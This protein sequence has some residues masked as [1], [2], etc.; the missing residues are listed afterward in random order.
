MASPDGKHISGRLGK[1]V[2]SITIA[3]KSKLVNQIIILCMH[4][5]AVF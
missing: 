1:L 3:G 5:V 4:L 2:E